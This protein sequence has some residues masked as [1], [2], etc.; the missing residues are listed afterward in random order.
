MPI[1]NEIH[2]KNGH[3]LYKSLAKKFLDSEYYLD[4]IELITEEY[5]KQC[6][7]CFVKF[8]SKKIMKSNKIILDEG[9]HFRML[10]N[11]TY[12]DNNFYKGKNKV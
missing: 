1:L 3:I 6:S 7:E 9:L 8:Y 12:L 2:E 4:G 5:T 11:I 10:V